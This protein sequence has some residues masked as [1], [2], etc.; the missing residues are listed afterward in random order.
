MR[1]MKTLPYVL[2]LAALPAMLLAQAGNFAAVDDSIC[3][4]LGS[5]ITYNVKSNDQ[6]PLPGGPVRLIGGSEC[7]GLG[8]DGNLFFLPDPV[9]DC[10]GEHQLA[11]QYLNCP[12]GALCVAKIKITVKCP[13]P[14]CFLVNLEDYLP[15]A[16][17]PIGGNPDV[18]CAFACEYSN[19][20]YYIAYNPTSS[21]AW[22]V[23][24]GGTYVAGAN[25]AEIVVTWGPQGAGTVSV[26]VTDNNNIATTIQI[27][28]QI[29][30]G[31]VAAFQ[32]V[33]SAVCRNSPVSFTNNSTG[34]S[35]FFWYFGDGNTSSMFQPTHQYTLPGSYTVTLVVTKNNYDAQGNPLCC[36]VDSTSAVVV[37]DSL[38]GPDIYCISTLC[39]G[40]SS[41]YWTDATNCSS[42][43][44]TVLDANGLPVPFAG[45][46]TDTISVGWGAGPFG[47][48]MLE[49]MGCDSAYCSQ[50]VTA[51]VPIISNTVAIAG[52]IAVCENAT[53]TYTVPKWLSVY[54]NW[55]VSGGTILA[56]QGTNVVTIQWG[57]APGPGMI[58][59]DYTSNFLGGLPG[60]DPADCAGTADLTVVIKPQ[61]TITGPQPAIVCKNAT[62]T[63]SATALPSP[64]YMWTITPAVPFSGQ[65]SNFITVNWNTA[66]GTYVITAAPVDT[67]KYCN[68]L[69]STIIRVI[70]LLPPDSITGP[71]EICPGAT[72]T[73]FGH[74]AQVG[75][76]FNWVVTNGLPASATGNPVTVAWG[77]SGPYNLVL[78]QFSL[79]AP[80]CNSD[81]I[82]LNLQPKLLNGPLVITGPTACTNSIQSYSA[83]P[84]QH[85]EA[86]YTWTVFPVSAGSVSSGQGSLNIQVQWNN[87]PGVATLTLTVQLC[88]N[89]L[90]KMQPITLNAAV[91]PV[92]TQNGV[93]CPGV[94]AILDA[95]GPFTAY[96]WSPAAPNTQ[97]IPITTGGTYIVTTTDANGCT[98]IDTYKAVPLP[99]PVAS[100]STGD[101][102]LLCIRSPQPDTVHIVAQTGPGYTFVWYCN[103]NLQPTP[104]PPHTF[105]H[106][107]TL[108]DTSFAYW[109]VVTDANGCTKQSNVIIVRQDSCLG[110]PGTDCQAQPY[111]LAFIA[112]NQ[113]PNCN[114]VNFAAA[115]SAN[116]TLIGWNFG[117]SLSNTNAGTLANAVHTYTLAKCYLVTVS[118]L[119]PQVAPDTGFC[120]V[121]FQ[122]KA[123]VPLAADFRFTDSCL[124][125]KFTDLSTFIPPN[126]PTNWL[127]SFGDATTSTLQYPVHNYLMPGTY[128]VT[129]TVSNLAGCQATIVKNVVVGGIAAPVLTATPNP[130]CVGVP[131]NFTGTAPGALFW[132]WSFN[133]GATNASQN[134]SHTYLL[135][136]TYQ[137]SLVVENAD[138]C[139]NFAIIPIIV[140]PAVPDDTIAYTPGRTVCAGNL[141]TLTAP[142]G[143]GYTY[144]WTTGAVTQTITA[145]VAG[146]YGVTITDANGCTLVPDPVTITILPAPPAF[147]AGPPVICDSGCTT[148]SAPLG[149]GYTYQWLDQSN[150]PLVPAQTGTTL[151]VCSGSLLPAYAVVVTDANGCSATS[152]PFTVSVAIS[153]AFTVTVSPNSCAGT[154]NIISLSPVQANVVYT[155]S[156]G[157]NGSSITVVQAGTYTVVGLDTLT[158]CTGNG[159]AVIHPLPDLCLTPVGCY[160]ICN[161]DTICGPAGLAAYQWN[162]HGVPIP[163]ETSV[164]LIVMQSGTYTLTGTTSFGCSLTSDSLVLLIKDCGCQDLSVSAEPSETDSCCWT[165]SYNNQFGALLGLNIHTTDADLD[166]NLNSLD[167]ALAVYSIG[168]NGIT[169][170]NNQYN[171][172]LP[173]GPLPGF[174]TFC[175]SNVV[176]S[177]QQI[178]FDW[179]D[180]EFQI[181]CSD[182]LIFNCPV[183]PDCLYLLADSIY[184]DHDTVRYSITVCNPIDNAFSV[185]YIAIIPSSPIGVVVTP[186]AINIVNNPM[187]PGECRTFT[188]TLS[189]PNLA[190]QVFCFNMT[191]HDN[192][193]EP[194]DTTTCC[195]LDTMYCVTIPDCDPCNDVGVEEVASVPGGGLNGCCYAISLYNNFGPNTFD[196]ISVCMLSANTTMTIT[197]PFGS[198]WYTDNYTPTMIGLSVVPP[199]GTSIPTGT[200]TLPT[201][202]ITTS[203]A[204]PQLV[205]IK[206]MQDGQIICRDTIELSCEPPCGYITEDTLIC[207]GTGGW[208]WQGSIKNT[209]AFVKGKANVVFTSPAG[210]GIYNQTINL[211]SLAPGA[212]QPFSLV[213]GAPAMP[214]DTIC[215]TVALHALDD[216]SMH[217]HCCNFTGCIV[218]PPCLPDLL[219]LCNDE[220]LSIGSYAITYETLNSSPQTAIFTPTGALT[221]CDELVWRWTE[222]GTTAQTLGSESISH[223][224]AIPGMYSVCI[225]INRMDVIGTKCNTQLCQDIE[226][227]A[228]SQTKEVTRTVEP[229]IFPNPTNDQLFVQLLPKWESA[230]QFQLYDVR[231]NALTAWRIPAAGLPQI[232]LDVSAVPKGIYI[233]SIATEGRKWMKKVVV[234]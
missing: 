233:L 125:V 119:V 198:G 57:T 67:T 10:C 1:K 213:L 16:S 73:Y 207:Q 102:T 205:E 183:E 94:P 51:I 118:G 34:G 121:V 148:L 196:G 69:A 24:G 218:L 88:N 68:N 202:C 77:P 192:I 184:C 25:P 40:D 62:S 178:I 193:P 216:D 50:P 180:F 83:G 111:N 177:P 146:S 234:L 5:P 130:A 52:A 217:T 215:F 132:L 8:P 185:G 189:G 31:P 212:T 97:M 181:A 81:T 103:G 138:G 210:L 223:T 46:G 6:P 100:I 49:V 29:L 106:I 135:P 120:L 200:F 144:L 149:L 53:A 232:P 195:S 71:L 182:T 44:W 139:R 190:G 226:I 127:W 131:I 158:G 33:D 209:S 151:T 150:N 137:D 14:E 89:S 64:N 126:N 18:S 39:A 147:I 65:G 208:V 224:F 104:A 191:A 166:F 28:V 93:L 225:V 229:T 48:I 74:S 221:T 211:G 96:Q 179:Y 66:P 123:C 222:S 75:T 60:Q 2:C 85:P 45:Q 128:S 107:N 175:L 95:G 122:D 116:M 162:L 113:V 3:V 115:A 168:T 201:I 58:H 80:F 154:P 228:V 204:P 4:M 143:T 11:Y 84:A 47:T 23:G 152:T 133:N 187:A 206:W 36:C 99:G 20:T 165:I 153:P 157:A 117:D 76:G 155:W 27:C 231:G 141:V 105:I 19:S 41:Q 70:E 134:P 219:C 86:T 35:S 174:L 63:F 176:Q 156:T 32:P 78:S 56:G 30:E 91:V 87:S 9:A 108:V 203:N 12:P 142:A 112:T 79:G 7:F 170:V 82:Q 13:K 160:E 161:P 15:D 22:T 169:L 109:V 101:P 124:T 173:G 72:Y 167:T 37:V 43:I 92:I 227:M 199:W 145:G 61:F 136:G 26:V 163:G 220:F 38:E 17:N 21:Y 214:G 230:V 140:F 55:Q 98:A 164:C 129:L 171:V 159:S 194:I 54:Y 114:V 186:P 42:Y 110:G 172:P 59:I 197:N 90:V 188:F